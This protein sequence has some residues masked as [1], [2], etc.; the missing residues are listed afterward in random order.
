MS[1]SPETL[2]SY[3]PASVVRRIATNPTPQ[4]APVVE[5]FPAAI[6]FADITGYTALAGRLAQHGSVGTEKL[7]RLLNAYFSQLIDIVVGHGGDIIKFAGD[8]ALILWP[9]I[10]ENI[11]TATYRATQCGLSMQESL[12]QY[13][14]ADGLKL[15]LRVGIGAGDITTANVGGVFNRWEF[16]VVGEPVN[17]STAAEHQAKPGQVVLSPEA[18][19]L[20]QNQYKGTV[21]MHEGHISGVLI[22]T[23]SDLL[24]LSRLKTIIPETAALDA[25]RSYIP[26]AVLSR[27]GA[28]QIEWISELRRIT[29]V[30]VNVRD[31]DFSAND[32]TDL[33]HTV[34]RTLQ[35]NIYCYEGSVNQFLVD[36]KG[37][38]LVAAFGL[39]PLSHEDDPT[40]G[41]K[42]SLALQK[43]LNE[44]RLR[45]SIGITTGYAY[46]GERGNA[47][48]REYAVVGNVVNMAARLM[49][50]ASKYNDS[51]VPILC[52]KTTHDAARATLLFDTL[53]PITVKGKTEPIAVFRPHS[54]VSLSEKILSSSYQHT[55][56]IGRAA[57]LEILKG[58][59]QNTANFSEVTN[60][61]TGGMAIIEAEAG[62]GKSCI[63]NELVR[64]AKALNIPCLVGNGEAV[65]RF[66]PYHAWQSIFCR[67]LSLPQDKHWYRINAGQEVLFTQVMN[68]LKSLQ[69]MLPLLPLLNS[70]IPLDFP[71]NETT[72][73]MDGQTRADNTRDLLVR[74]LQNTIKTPTLLI[75]E[76]A[77]WMDSSSWMLALA[78]SQQVSSLTM[79]VVMRT[80]TVLPPKEYHQLSLSAKGKQ[81]IKLEA[82]CYDDTKKLVCQRLGLT[83]LPERIAALIHDKAQGNPFFI[84]ELAHALCVRG[85]VLI[86]NGE[87][88]M[89]SSIDNLNTLRLPDTINGMIT[90]RIDRLTPVQQMVLKVAS[91][92]GRIFT[93][94]TLCDIYPIEEDKPNLLD[95]LATL[96][97]VDI[98]ALDTTS[99]DSVYSFKNSSIQEAAYNLMLFSQRQQLHLAVAEWYE[100]TYIKDLSPFYPLLA[101]HLSKVA[102]NPH[103]DHALVSK[104]INYLEKAGEQT[105]HNNANQEAVQFFTEAIKLDS[106]QPLEPELKTKQL[107]GTQR[108]LRCAR[109]ERQAGEAYLNMGH[110]SESREHLERALALMKRQVF[111]TP[112][113]FAVSMGKQI[114][115]QSLHRLGLRRFNIVTTLSGAKQAAIYKL[116][117]LHGTEA[118]LMESG[119][120][121]WLLGQVYFYTNEKLLN[122]HAN[123]C[124]LNLAEAAGAT[125]DLARSYA[126][127]CI[128]A[129]FVG[130]H[131]LAKYYG[132]CAVKT[133]QSLN[134]LPSLT[135]VLLVTAVYEAGIGNWSDAASKTRQAIESSNLYGDRRR[136]EQSMNTLAIVSCLQGQF[137]KFKKMFA[138]LYESACRRGDGQYQV[139]GLLGQVVCL[140]PA[141][142]TDESVSFLAKV[143]NL[144]QGNIGR[145]GEIYFYGLN[146]LALLR[147]GQHI[148]ARQSADKAINLIS[149]SRPISY[150]LVYAYAAVAETYLT[151]WEIE[152]SKN[153]NQISEL[154]E[155]SR[156]ACQS[157]H[158][159]SQIFPIGQPNDWICQGWYN[160]L[161]GDKARAYKAWRRAIAAAERL[162]MPYE[163]G[164]AH[165]EIRRHGIGFE[166]K[167]HLACARELFT[168]LGAEYN[169]KLIRLTEDACQF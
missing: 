114:V 116:E 21:L 6:L 40:R 14:V 35:T 135:W 153:K 136:W 117:D 57:E 144:L 69:D 23:K 94:R 61:K 53:E 104:A 26:G 79:L 103:A 85:I 44:L 29:V 87:C 25:L 97:Q 43:S 81:T 93:L 62:A 50:A 105:L 8:A 154:N 80:L 100:R 124:S 55:D 42:A 155:I 149:K 90:G 147:H 99:G 108:M 66:T 127:A 67:C 130:Q 110:L 60:D 75:L 113:K 151:L 82:L 156:Q 84:S 120:T 126:S 164:R 98:V 115:I 56:I 16:I 39:P 19:S 2:A 47:I 132:R 59:L 10:D 146:A 91:V 13:E 58:L 139:Y 160:W 27:L 52:D 88:R 95:Y 111:K 96:L 7:P 64:Q 22:E 71:D 32:A 89:A 133:A 118:G 140:L 18:W 109:W 20:M 165:Y 169:L 86:N 138:D 141:G 11:A 145:M 150:S 102:E 163:R 34:M 38:T 83:N 49:Q 46:C 4:T 3:V 63:V 161:K 41:V 54:A 121:N 168:T 36:D 122:I 76:D 30:F 167:K 48:R 28:G 65:E 73:Q 24:P 119:R 77:H 148:P 68:Q 134:H 51:T 162:S 9:A 15:S 17:Q 74:L 125:P 128:T 45:C 12:Y 129:G 70:V 1:L 33:L 123:L 72:R 37:T 106:R 143:E 159:F 92:I 158:K 78:V 137:A 5:R 112:W 131:K 31:I 152:Q 142:K 157:L 166:Q 101:H 107:T